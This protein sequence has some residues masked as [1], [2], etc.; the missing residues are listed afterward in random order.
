MV[1]TA[2]TGATDKLAPVSPKIGGWICTKKTAV[3]A[4]NIN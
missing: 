1:K 4:K 3:T 2:D